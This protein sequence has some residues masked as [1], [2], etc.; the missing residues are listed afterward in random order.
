MR[1][2]E[3]EGE[4]IIGEFRDTESGHKKCN[5]SFWREKSVFLGD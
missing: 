2:E 1:L 3:V 5:E 4:K